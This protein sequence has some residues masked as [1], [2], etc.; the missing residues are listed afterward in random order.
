[1]I[2]DRLGANPVPVQIPIGAESGFKGIIDLL[3]QKALTFGEKP[4]DPIQEGPIPAEL[5]DEADP[6]AGR[7]DREDRRVRR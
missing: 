1:M 2:I 7:G 3:E 4:N 6:Q 5:Q